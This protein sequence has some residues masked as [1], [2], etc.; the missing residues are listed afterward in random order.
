[1]SSVRLY[2]KSL[3]SLPLFLRMY[4]LLSVLL[5]R[6]MTTHTCPAGKSLMC[7]YRLHCYY[8][9]MDTNLAGTQHTDTGPSSVKVTLYSV[10]RLGTCIVGRILWAATTLRSVPCRW[11]MTNLIWETRVRKLENVQTCKQNMNAA[12]VSFHVSSRS[13]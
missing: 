2:I 4:C 12:T 6:S 7:A 1:M 5:F 10:V 13:A 9:S 11:S 3:V 8:S